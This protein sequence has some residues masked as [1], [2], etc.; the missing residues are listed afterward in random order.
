MYYDHNI[1]SF[2][3]FVASNTALNIPIQYVFM[4]EKAITQILET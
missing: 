4:D 2:G 1:N 3:Y